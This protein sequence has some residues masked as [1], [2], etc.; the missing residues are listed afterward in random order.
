MLLF[1]EMLR[2]KNI[3]FEVMRENANLKSQLESLQNCIQSLQLGMLNQTSL[4]QSVGIESKSTIEEP[5]RGNNDG[6]MNL[7]D[8]R[9]L[10]LQT[11][12]ETK[13]ENFLLK[14]ELTKCRYRFQWNK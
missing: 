13:D 4:T 10:E 9:A 3:N 1:L 7:D 14:A 5:P 2:Q 11:W 6:N 8:S 12:R